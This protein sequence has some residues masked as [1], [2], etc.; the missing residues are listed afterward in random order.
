MVTLGYG[1]RKQAKYWL[2]DEDWNAFKEKI[3]K[4]KE[5]NEISIGRVTDYTV[6]SG[7]KTIGGGK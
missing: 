1:Y 5:F 7:A 4:L 2:S 6:N 3:A